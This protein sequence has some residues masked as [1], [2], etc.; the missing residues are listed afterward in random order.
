MWLE[1]YGRRLTNLALIKISKLASF[2]KQAARAPEN[3]AKV[4]AQRWF[5]ISS[6][7]SVLGYVP[8]KTVAQDD[9]GLEGCRESWIYVA[10]VRH[11]MVCKM[12]IKP[13]DVHKKLQ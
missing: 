4:F 2:R 12:E 9:G 5:D 10:V 1:K 13:Y 3:R 8:S 6:A 7:R 11:L